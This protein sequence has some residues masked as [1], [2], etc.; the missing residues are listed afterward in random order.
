[1]DKFAHGSVRFL[2]TTDLAAR[3]L[4]FDQ[5]AHVINFDLPS[6]LTAYIH[7]VGRTARIGQDGVAISLVDETADVEVMRKVLTISG[8][9]NGHQVASV[10]RRDIASDEL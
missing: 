10:K 7:R 4:D 9:I 8:A 3:G 1:M 2:I 6:T 5:V